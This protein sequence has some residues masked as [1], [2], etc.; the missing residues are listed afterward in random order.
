VLPSPNSD[1]REGERSRA[2][3]LCYDS[4]PHHD[5]SRENAHPWARYKGLLPSI[6]FTS[7]LLVV[8]PFTRLSVTVPTLLQWPPERFF[9][10]LLWQP[11]SW[12]L[13]FSRSVRP[14]HPPGKEN[15]HSQPVVCLANKPTL[16]ANAA[17]M[18]GPVP[19]P[20]V[21]A[22]PVLSTTPGTPSA[23]LVAR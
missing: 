17:A 11:A 16:G 10:Q 12:P 21:P 19:Q 6:S 15:S 1:H 22:A 7:F 8:R 14:A 18:A 4:P 23:C 9:L 20:A 2:S 13:P 5:G 3:D